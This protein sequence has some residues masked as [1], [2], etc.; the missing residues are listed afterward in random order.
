MSSYQFPTEEH[1]FGYIS[2]AKMMKHKHLVT[3]LIN[4]MVY[5]TSE[6]TVIV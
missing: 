6:I 2:E 4:C 1:T 3:V 5:N